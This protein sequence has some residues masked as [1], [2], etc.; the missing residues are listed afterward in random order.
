MSA[1]EHH[2]HSCCVI[3]ATIAYDA[4]YLLCKSAFNQRDPEKCTVRERGWGRFGTQHADHPLSEARSYA[5]I[6]NTTR[7]AP[8]LQ[9]LVFPMHKF[10]LWVPAVGLTRLFCR[11]V[12]SIAGFSWLEWFASLDGGALACSFASRVQASGGGVVRISRLML[13]SRRHHG[14]AR[15]V[16]C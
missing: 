8:R 3:W 5:Q 1:P 12:R 7:L 9:C 4:S 11:C 6:H 2:V 13:S 15:W 16:E 10:T 14:C